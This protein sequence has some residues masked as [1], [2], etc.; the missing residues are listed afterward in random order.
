MRHL[1]LSHGCS[2]GIIQN[3]FGFHKVCAKWVPKQLPGKHKRNRL[4]ICKGLL[5]R[6][7]NE[8]DVLSL[9]ARR[10][11]TIALQKFKTEPQREK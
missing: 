11:S 4:T 5:N 7:F 9:R 8:G 10:G 6:Y 1:P 3:R 2:H